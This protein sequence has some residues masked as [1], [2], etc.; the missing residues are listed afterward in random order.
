M[1]LEDCL[2]PD[3][4]ARRWACRGGSLSPNLQGQQTIP[5]TL[6][7]TLPLTLALTLPLTSPPRHPRIG[8]RRQRRPARAPGTDSSIQTACVRRLGGPAS[9]SSSVRR[10]RGAAHRDCTAL[11]GHVH[12]PLPVDV[13]NNNHHRRA[14]S[15]KR[16]PRRTTSAPDRVVTGVWKEGQVIRCQCLPPKRAMLRLSIRP[17]RVA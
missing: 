7:F 1:T 9:R 10:T 2:H 6:P 8:G 17:W 3:A 14:P 15:R 5:F 13:S 4:A 16:R 12:D 11:L